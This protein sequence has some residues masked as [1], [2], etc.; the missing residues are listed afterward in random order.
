MEN[1]TGKYFKYAIGEIILVVI[2]ILIA[3]SINN[4]NEHRKNKILWRSY[5]KSL[6]Q[7][8]KKDIIT[9]NMVTNY[10]KNDSISIEKLNKRLSSENATI[11]TLK[12]IARYEINPN[13]KAYR[14]PNNKTFLAMQANMSIEL[15]DD[16][17]Y[18]LLLDLHNIQIIAESIIKSNNNAYLTQ[19]SNFASKYS[20][21]EFNAIKGPLSDKAWKNVDADDLYRRVEGLLSIKQVMNRYTCQ[22]YMDVFGATEKTLNRLK[23]V[24]QDEK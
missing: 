1:K 12:K 8:L 21:N 11:D 9:L 10:I 17:T 16:K 19:I 20:L 4:W 7:D 23:E 15:F 2:G 5:T 14:P 3:L 24:Q 13:N 6:I 18:S 22:R